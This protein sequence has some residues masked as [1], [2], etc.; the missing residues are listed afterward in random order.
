[1]IVKVKN[2]TD[3]AR[4]W[5]G[6]TIE[7]GAY[8]E[9]QAIEALKWA[10]DADVFASVGDADL[11][12]ND[13]TTDFTDPVAGWNW[14]IGNQP[15]AKKTLDDKLYTQETSRPIGTTIY[16]TSRGDA[17]SGTSTMST[18]VGHGE[19]LQI[20]HKPG[21][22]TEQSIYLD[23]NTMENTTYMHEGYVIWKG[24]DFDTVTMSGVPAVTPYAPGTG[25]FFNLY[26]G[27]LIVPA[28]GDGNIQVD[29]AQA[30][31]VE[32]IIGRD[33]G[34]PAGPGYWNTTYDSVTH[35]FG[36]LTAAPY[37]DGTYNI[38]GAEIDLLRYVN[39]MSLLEGGFMMMQTADVEE[40]GH[41]IRLKMVL[42]TNTDETDHAWKAG[43]ILAMNRIKT[44]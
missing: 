19:R 12:V 36:D 10:A 3:S 27:F 17:T 22:A 35:T 37:G 11:L 2:N 23:F 31:L 44:A 34:L 29:P 21:D 26:G 6:Q 25:T 28:A 16:F 15:V 5:C 32:V 41:G 1:M 7:A 20:V 42:R 9:I 14:L 13:G 24:A 18:D 40:I 33:T 38:F 8:Y 4:T 43:F 30:K 39:E